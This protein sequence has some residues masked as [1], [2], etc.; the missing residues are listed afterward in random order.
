MLHVFS[1][2]K[3]AARARRDLLRELSPLEALPK[4]LRHLVEVKFVLGHPPLAE[5][6]DLF[7]SEQM[8]ADEQAQHGDLLRLY[9]LEGGDNMDHG[10]TWEWI[11]YVGRENGRDALWVVKMDGDV[12]RRA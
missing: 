7:D 1:T 11:R 2:P 10:K 9:N 6:D 3:K 4:R 12:S 8:L 5:G